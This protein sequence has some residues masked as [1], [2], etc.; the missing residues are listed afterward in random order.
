M[1]GVFD[2]KDKSLNLAFSGICTAISVVLLYIASV[3]PTARL[4]LCA[5]A[6]ATVCLVMIKSGVKGAFTLYFAVTVLSAIILPDKAIAIAYG[7]VFG[8]YPIIKALIEKRHNL[9]VE[10]LFKLI[11]FII[12]SA[13]FFVVSSY[14]LPGLINAKL[15]APII[16]IGVIAVLVVYDIALSLIIT[17][18]VRRFSKILN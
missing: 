2:I 1:S 18:A 9:Y 13:L 11:V 6:S 4:A 15:S 8:I 12:Y 5:V 16:L 7:G 3:V 10:W 14:F 17:E